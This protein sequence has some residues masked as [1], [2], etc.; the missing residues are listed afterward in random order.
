MQKNGTA[1]ALENR[2]DS[3]KSSVRDLVDA[4]GERADQLKS[5]AIDVKDAVVEN[6]GKYLDRGVTLVK[7]NPFVAIGVAFGVG[8]LVIRMLRK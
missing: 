6:G 4:G 3:L 2:F 1:S 5:K 7:E 8:Y